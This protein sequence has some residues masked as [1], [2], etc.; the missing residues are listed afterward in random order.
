MAFCKPTVTP[1]AEVA[2][3]T[4]VN[5]EAVNEIAAPNTVGV[6]AASTVAAPNTFA[7][8]TAAGIPALCDGE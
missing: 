1:I 4:V 2:A 5:G 6:K 3:P 7:P 8:I